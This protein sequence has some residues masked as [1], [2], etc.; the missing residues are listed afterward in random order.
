MNEKPAATAAIISP[1]LRGQVF[2]GN[3]AC[4]STQF[5]PAQVVASVLASLLTV[6]A[7][8]I[9]YVYRQEYY[10]FTIHS[11]GYLCA[12]F[13]DAWAGLGERLTVSVL[14]AKILLIAT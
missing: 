6:A 12:H 4:I 2:V 1:C 5:S 3:Y 8:G 13:L 10:Y 11:S 14:H 9:V 7:E